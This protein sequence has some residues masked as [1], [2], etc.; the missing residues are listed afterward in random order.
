MIP[1]TEPLH[2]IHGR[3]PQCA[4]PTW[5][6]LLENAI[7]GKVTRLWLKVDAVHSAGDAGDGVCGYHEHHCVTEAA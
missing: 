2:A 5:Q 6:V 3:C 4:K 1:V 7:E